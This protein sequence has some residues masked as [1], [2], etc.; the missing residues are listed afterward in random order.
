MAYEGFEI[1]RIGPN[2]PDSE[3]VNLG[4]L[5]GSARS[6]VDDSLA[7]TYPDTQGEYF[8]QIIADCNPGRSLRTVFVEYEI[9]EC[10]SFVRGDA[11]GDGE[12]I[13]PFAE[14]E[15]N[16]SVV[17]VENSDGTFD[18]LPPPPLLP[19]N[20]RADIE[21]QVE[22]ILFNIDNKVPLPQ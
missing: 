5:A 8:Y 15:A 20:F 10:A 4:T 13:V 11:N 22:H 21:V 12:P 3:D 6:F 14:A 7:E 17:L 19:R 9:P 2:G 16:T 1:R 18:A